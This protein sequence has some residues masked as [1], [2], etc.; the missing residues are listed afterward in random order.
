MVKFVILQLSLVF[1]SLSLLYFIFVCFFLLYTG[2]NDF[3]QFYPCIHHC[4]F[5]GKAGENI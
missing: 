3:E 1:A 4:Y 5:Q 2:N